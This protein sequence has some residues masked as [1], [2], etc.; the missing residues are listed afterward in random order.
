ME[1]HRRKRC[2]YCNKYYPE[3]EF[4]IALTT[5]NKVYRRRKCKSCYRNTKKNLQKK[6]KNWINEYKNKR[7]CIKCG[8][9]DYRVLDLHHK[10]GN[11]K[12]FSLGMIL[13]N[14]YGFSRIKKEADKC[15]V[16]CANCHR[17]LHYKEKNRN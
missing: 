6:Y 1:S 3:N 10:D 16:I 12:E 14:G 2:K 8:I 17:I 13:T 11:K 4:G 5:K 9:K 15:I 7:G